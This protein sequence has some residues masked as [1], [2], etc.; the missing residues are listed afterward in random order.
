MDRVRLGLVGLGWW[1]GMLADAARKTGNAQV[2]ACFS[3]SAN[4]R[5]AFTAAHGGRPV[6]SLDALLADS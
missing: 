1:G 6:D 5:A 2:V 3:R 4:N